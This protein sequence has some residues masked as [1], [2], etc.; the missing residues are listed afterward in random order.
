MFL[1]GLVICVT[2]QLMLVVEGIPLTEKRV[3]IIGLTENEAK[4]AEGSDR[5]MFT[6]CFSDKFHRFY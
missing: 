3:E 2:S 1:I 5:L 6:L 4:E